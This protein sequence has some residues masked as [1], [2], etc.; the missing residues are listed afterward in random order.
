ML[1][2]IDFVDSC[3]H[4]RR[5]ESEGDQTDDNAALVAENSPAEVGEEI[6]QHE[7]ADAH[8]DENKSSGHRQPH[9]GLNRAQVRVLVW[10]EVLDTLD[11]L[12]HLDVTHACVQHHYDEDQERCHSFDHAVSEVPRDMPV[13][14]LKCLLYTSLKFY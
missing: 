7:T 1:I 13:A 11:R 8:A 14:Q 10:I 6:E 12:T 2:H 9:P 3:G 5:V 4:S